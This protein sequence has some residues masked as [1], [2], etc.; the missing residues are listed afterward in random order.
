MNLTHLKSGERYLFCKENRNGSFEYFRA[1]FLALY[2]MPRS[3]TIIC[4][5]PDE[6]RNRL[7]YHMDSHNIIM[8]E[9]LVNLMEEHLCRLPDDVLGVINSFW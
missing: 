4:H 8:A 3:I 9:T 6:P 2:Q 5:H 7:V 1:T